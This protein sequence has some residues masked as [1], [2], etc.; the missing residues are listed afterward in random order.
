MKKTT[1]TVQNA[2]K[3][4]YEE[5]LEKDGREAVHEKRRRKIRFNK[6]LFR[7]AVFLVF[8]ILKSVLCLS[9]LG[10]MP[11]IFWYSNDLNTN[12]FGAFLLILVMMFYAI[13]IVLSLVCFLLN[14]IRMRMFGKAW[15]TLTLI[16]VV[17]PLPAL[18]VGALTSAAQPLST[19]LLCLCI[20]MQAVPSILEINQLEKKLAEKRNERKNKVNKNG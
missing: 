19:I 18:A 4:H 17:C 8:V 16:S 5:I 9:A 11:V 2:E 13:S 10:M 1:E 20:G 15:N 12:L 3:S 6:D 7:K 14:F